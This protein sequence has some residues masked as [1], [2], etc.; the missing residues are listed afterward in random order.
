MKAEIK[1]RLKGMLAGA[2]FALPAVAV[3]ADGVSIG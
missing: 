2:F 3:A 1:C